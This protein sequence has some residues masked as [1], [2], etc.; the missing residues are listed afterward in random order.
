MHI[1]SYQF[2]R[3]VI[4]GTAYSS[5]CLIAGDSVQP[6]WRRKQGHS[7]APEDLQLVVAAGPATL[8]VGCGASGQMKVAEATRQAL[9]QQNIELIALDTDEAVAKYNELTA[10][11]ENVGAALHL[12]C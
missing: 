2:G 1:D 12:T 3:I 10:S 8:V 6:D 5:D 7:L 4:D 11:G 9:Q